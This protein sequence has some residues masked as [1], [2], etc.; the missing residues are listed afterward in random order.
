MRKQ[1]SKLPEVDNL[2]FHQAPIPLLCQEGFHISFHA[3][4]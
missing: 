4:Q 1:Y 2:L 3:E